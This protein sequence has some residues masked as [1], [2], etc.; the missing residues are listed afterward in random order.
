[1]RKFL[2]FILILGLL[3]PASAS[4]AERK[5]LALIY[6]GCP[7]E[8]SSLL[9][10]LEKRNARM[11]FFLREEDSRKAETLLNQ[12]HELGILTDAGPKLSRREIAGELKAREQQINAQVRLLQTTAGCSDGM[13]QVAKALGFSFV[14]PAGNLRALSPAKDGEILLADRNM[15][16]I[17]LLE[18]VD[19]LQDQGFKLVTV[20]E[21]ARVRGVTLRPGTLYRSFPPEK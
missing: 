15:A 2:I 21:L 10:G 4:A 8:L 19:D 12:G 1:M 14:V 17:S 9:D 18:L 5:Y 3:C 20:S 6:D 13:R 11:T 7:R 16:A